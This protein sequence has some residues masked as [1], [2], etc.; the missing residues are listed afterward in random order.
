MPRLRND[1][2][3]GQDL[4]TFMVTE[5]QNDISLVY[6]AGIAF[7]E[8]LSDCSAKRGTYHTVGCNRLFSKY[9]VTSN[10]QDSKFYAGGTRV[11]DLLIE[12][13]EEYNWS[14]EA[15]EMALGAALSRQKPK[16]VI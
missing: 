10:L 4:E 1:I 5:Y 13:C 14:E 16:R 12:L 3:E 15:L 11:K 7:L 2:E 9:L 6:Q 8:M